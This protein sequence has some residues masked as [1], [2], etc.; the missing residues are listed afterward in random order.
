VKPFGT[1]TACFPHVDEDTRNILQSVMDEAK[2]Y[3]DF[4]E[5]LCNKACV[6]SFPPLANYFACYFAYNQGNYNLVDRLVEAQIFSD[7]AKPLLLIVQSS[8]GEH[9]KWSDFQKSIGVS[10]KA[11]QSDW[12]ACHIYITWRDIAER[13]YY[14]S[15]TDSGPLDLLESKIVDDS[16]FSFFVSDLYSIKANRLRKERNIDEATKSYNRAILQAKKHDN[17]L[18]LAILLAE[19]ANLVKRTNID[20]ALS[21]LKIQREVSGEIGFIT[22]FGLNDHHLG[23][24]AMARG[25]FDLGIQHQNRCF[26]NES[27]R[28]VPTGFLSCVIAHLYNLMG[29]GKR[30]LELSTRALQENVVSL[31]PFAR[32]QEAWAMLNL[33]RVDDAET[34]LTKAREL[35]L[36]MND[37]VRLGV[38]Y[39]VEGLIEKSRREYASASYT[40]EN[41]LEI[42]MRNYA[43]IY[44]S[45]TLLHL[46]DIEIEAFA[47]EKDTKAKFSGPWM[48]RLMKHVEDRKL[49]GI[50]AQA[51]LLQAKFQFKQGLT[52]QAKKLLKKVLKTSES[53]SMDYLKTMAETV[54]PE[55]LIS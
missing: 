40:L 21:I 8:R 16:E 30:A 22:G 27:L 25:E 14:E 36:K 54:L 33:E 37:E 52:A 48:Q 24:I 39:F 9:V 4:A 53:S 3:G 2:D 46:T 32:I 20:E 12:I 34:S 44:I 17:R 5:I 47:Y 28:G 11:T 13:L 55:L 6:E 45:M 29:D 50:A 23:L 1:I 43:S 18:L 15:F 41:A 26:K 19:K 7:L 35:I 38:T 31:T 51:M 10:L 49:P 42:F